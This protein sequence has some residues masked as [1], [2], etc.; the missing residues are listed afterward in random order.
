M[1]RGKKKG[2]DTKKFDRCIIKVKKKSGKRASPYAVC[3][4]TMFVR[5]INS[6]FKQKVVLQLADLFGQQ[7]FDRFREKEQ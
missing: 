2:L 6:Q 5:D 3:N 1:L 7:L 4:T